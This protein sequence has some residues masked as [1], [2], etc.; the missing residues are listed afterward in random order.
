MNKTLLFCLPFAYLSAM[1]NGNPEFPTIIDQGVIFTKEKDFTFDTGYQKVNVNIFKNYQLYSTLGSTQLKLNQSLRSNEEVIYTSSNTFTFG[2]GGKMLIW[3]GFNFSVGI[4]GKYQ[5][6]CPQFPTITKDGTLID[7]TKM[8]YLSFYAWQIGASV[9][10]HIDIF[11]PYIG[12]KYL[13]QRGH[14]QKLKSGI[15]SY[16]DDDF[17][18]SNRIPVGGFVGLTM[19]SGKDFSFTIESRFLDE[20]S[21]TLFFDLRF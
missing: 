11:S 6:A 10:Y 15:I 16:L 9:A 20:N 2:L 14:F 8:A 19:S 1:Y 17:Y 21:L 3:Q 4:D 7:Q 13:N 12:A 5:Y 18:V